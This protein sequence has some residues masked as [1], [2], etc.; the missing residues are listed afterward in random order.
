MAKRERSATTKA[1][2]DRLVTLIDEKKKQGIIIANIAESTGI[3]SGSI[4]NY[5]NNAAVAGIDSLIKFSNYFNVSTDYLL[6]ISPNTTTDENIKTA[7]KVTGL[8]ETSIK[9]IIATQEEVIKKFNIYKNV[10]DDILKSNKL[11]NF[12]G[13]VGR[14]QMNQLLTPAMDKLKNITS[15]IKER[16]MSEEEKLY[17]DADNTYNA[18]KVQHTVEY[19]AV[20]IAKDTSNVKEGK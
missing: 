5:Q 15:E 9:N 20:E 10:L 8:S 14:Y 2:A 3:P 19:F 1:F 7:C 13:A 16:I 17:Y 6:G 11:I 4:S 12:I 18:D